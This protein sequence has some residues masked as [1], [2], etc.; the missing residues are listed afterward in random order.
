MVRAAAR[1]SWLFGAILILSLIW[2]RVTYKLA[3][4][5]HKC[6]NGSAPEYLAEFCHPSADRRPGMRSADSWKLHVPRTQ[7]SFG[8]RSFAVTGPRTWNNLWWYPRFVS[9][10]LDIHKTVKIISVC[11]TA[12]ARVIFN[13]HLTNV[14][15]NL[16]NWYAAAKRTLMAADGC[17][18]SIIDWAQNHSANNGG[19]NYL[20]QKLRIRSTS[21][22]PDGPAHVLVLM[23][24]LTHCLFSMTTKSAV[25]EIIT[26]QQ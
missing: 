21:C 8:D 4:L 22:C 26:T 5:V 1:L 9:V 3:T 12:A 18:F 20:W 25:V 19:K 17:E 16:L 11:L 10:I 15:T 14:L 23:F 7:T 6:I 13:W 24:S 2:E